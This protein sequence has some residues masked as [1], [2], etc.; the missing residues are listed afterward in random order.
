MLP[1]SPQLAYRGAQLVLEDVALADLAA[2]HGTP[3]YAYSKAS[4]LG[5][6]ANYQ[7]A[8]AGREHLIC[9]AMKA[10]SSLAATVSMS[11]MGITPLTRTVGGFKKR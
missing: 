5:A 4:M 3:L 6:L 8:L 10:N 11:S 2:R 9:Y 7:R 1:G